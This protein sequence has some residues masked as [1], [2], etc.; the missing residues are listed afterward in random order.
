MSW[1]GGGNWAELA[2]GCEP[3]IGIAVAFGQDLGSVDVGDGADFGNA[4]FAAVDGW[5]DREEM[6]QGEFVGPFHG[7]G[8]GSADFEGWAGPGVVV[9]PESCGGKIAMNF[10]TEGADVNGDGGSG[11]QGTNHGRDGQRIDVVGEGNWLLR[12]GCV[13]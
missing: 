1:I 7:Q 11:L 3:G 4:R 13:E 10:L 12:Q 5:V 2:V 9:S 6:F 8:L